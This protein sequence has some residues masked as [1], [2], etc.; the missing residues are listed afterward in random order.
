MYKQLLEGSTLSSMKPFEEMGYCSQVQWLI[1]KQK[2][3]IIA[4]ILPYLGK[5]LDET[6]KKVFL[7]F[8]F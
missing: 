2:R 1:F 6:W 8:L 4:F 3:R 7:A 5:R